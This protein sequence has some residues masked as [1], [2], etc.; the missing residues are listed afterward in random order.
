MADQLEH[1][2]LELHSNGEIKRNHFSQRQFRILSPPL[3]PSAGGGSGMRPLLDPF[4]PAAGEYDGS[5]DETDA[6]PLVG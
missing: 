6:R 3:R 5:T 1:K 4:L 2:L